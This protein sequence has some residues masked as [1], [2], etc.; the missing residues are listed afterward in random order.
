[1][2]APQ[3]LHTD[4]RETSDEYGRVVHREDNWRVAECRDQIQ[5]LLQ[6][7][8]PGYAGVGTA[9]DTL[10]Y[11]VTRAVLVRLYRQHSGSDAAILETV[12][13]EYFPRASR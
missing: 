3:H 9:W 13:P 1:M 5:W 2:N 7:R 10:A 6:R 4:H 8:R 12:L 11:C